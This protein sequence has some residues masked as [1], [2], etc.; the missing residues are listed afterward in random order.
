M[1]TSENITGDAQALALAVERRAQQAYEDLLA[2]LDEGVDPRLAIAQVQKSFDGEFAGELAQAFST[3]LQRSVSVGSVLAMPV[4]EVVLSRRLWALNGEVVNQVSG[5]IRQHAQ[6][7]QSAQTLARQLY[8]GYNPIDGVQRP[9]EG[10]ARAKLPKAL[11]E[12]IRLPQTR[13]SL[14]R[15]LEQGQQLAARIKSETLKAGY[16]EAVQ[17]WV[18]GEGKQA[19]NKR[20]WVAQREKNRYTADRIAQT[21]LARAHQAKVGAE[22]MADGSISVVQVRINPAHP[23]TDI[24]DLHAR[25][26]LFGLGAGCYPKAKAPRPPFHPHCW[27]RLSSRPDLMAGADT[28]ERKGAVQAYLRTLPA[29]EA[30]RVLGSRERL[31]QVLGGKSVDAVVNAGRDPMYHLARLGGMTQDP[32]PVATQKRI[33]DFARDAM[34]I[35]DRRTIEVI[36]KVDNATLILQKTGLDVNGFTRVIDNYGVRHT[37]KQ[38]GDATKEAR[39]GQLAV[40]P[41]DFGLIPMITSHPDSVYSDGKNKIGRDVIVFEKVIDG[42]GYRHVEELRGK[43]K[44]VATDSMRKKKGTWGA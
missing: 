44:L 40:T 39:R 22:L 10:A 42:V 28:A 37:L 14:A 19:L 27:C 8:D 23:V 9:L 30:A 38:H 16:L 36:G 29:Y 15:V 25:A 33:A 13:E 41:D 1:P 6:G 11:R 7:L 31:A 43:H 18:D 4:G 5:L 20:L 17:A 2:K 3:V 21:E 26:D 24:C 34:N 32:T 12:L 35:S